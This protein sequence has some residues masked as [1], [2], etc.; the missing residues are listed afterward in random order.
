MIVAIPPDFDE[1]LALCSRMDKNQ[2][3]VI[4]AMMIT[5]RST[6]YSRPIYP[7][8]KCKRNPPFRPDQN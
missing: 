4:R 8:R 6:K 3:A 1:F 5:I 2:R 7:K